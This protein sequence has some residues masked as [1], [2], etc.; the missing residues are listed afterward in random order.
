MKILPWSSQYETPRGS[1]GKRVWALKDWCWALQIHKDIAQTAEKNPSSG[2]FLPIIIFLKCS[3]MYI[4]LGLMW[5]SMFHCELGVS[6]TYGLHVTSTC[7]H[8]L[9]KSKMQFKK[10]L[11]V[12]SYAQLTRS[13]FTIQRCNS[14]I[15]YHS[16]MHHWKN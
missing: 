1:P 8:P 12:I 10:C 6:L 4:H 11:S 14:R 3:Y 7:S 13:V 16:M 9:L 5:S 2:T 15:N